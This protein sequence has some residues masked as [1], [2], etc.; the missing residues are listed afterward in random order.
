VLLQIQLQQYLPIFQR[1]E[2]DFTTFLTLNEQSLKSIG[3][4]N[5]SHRKILLIYIK[6]L[7]QLLTSATTTTTTTENNMSQIPENENRSTL[8]TFDD[9]ELIKDDSQVQVGHVLTPITEEEEP[10]FPVTNVLPEEVNDLQNSNPTNVAQTNLNKI[11]APIIPNSSTTNSN[12]I[13]DNQDETQSNSMSSS[14]D[15]ED[16][17]TPI[18]LT[19][20]GR[21]HNSTDNNLMLAM[22]RQR[23]A[24]VR[25]TN[26]RLSEPVTNVESPSLP[27][28]FD[29]VDRH[30]IKKDEGGQEELPPYSCTVHKAGYVFKKNEFVSKGMKARDRSWK[31]QY[32]YLWGTFLRIY[33]S[34]PVDF[35]VSLHFNKH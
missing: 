22:R 30:V 32:I 11:T 15:M 10:C 6:K 26:W 27:S 8:E 14:V 23:G 29:L 2:I 25:D 5:E 17:Y 3:V 12:D 21:K 19:P 31:Q 1:N 9:D 7:Q 24:A 4:K 33:K 28:Y 34:E 16:D 18:S 35:N 13:D 20:R